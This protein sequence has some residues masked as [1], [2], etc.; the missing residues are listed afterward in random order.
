MQMQQIFVPQVLAQKP[1]TMPSA[2]SFLHYLERF[3]QEAS[4]KQRPKPTWR[5]GAIEKTKSPAGCGA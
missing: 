4:G 2:V 3:V 5:R 1:S